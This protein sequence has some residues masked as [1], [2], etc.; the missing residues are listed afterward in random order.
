[1]AD[2]RLVVGLG[3]PGPEYAETRHNL[4]FKVIEALDEALGI[5]VEQQKFGARIGEGWYRER[6]VMLM[7]PWQFMNRSGQAV[8]TAVGFYKLGFEDLM[9]IT[10]DKALAP[11]RIRIR[12]KGSA[13]GHNGLSD[14]IARLG[15]DEFA[16]CRVGIGDCPGALSVDYVLG[17]PREEERPLINE[18][19]V[20]ARDAVLC[21]L[22]SGIDRAMSEF[23]SPPV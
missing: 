18:A 3:N 6:K 17:R 12:A 1:M 21:W 9:V 22:E 5:A 20:R 14:I 11:G 7:K 2:L 23:N 15:S 4:G 10:D 13:G 19:I 16:R 8:A